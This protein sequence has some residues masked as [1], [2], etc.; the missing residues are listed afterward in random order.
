MDLPG[1]VL[2]AGSLPRIQAWLRSPAYGNS[3]TSNISLNI[4]LPLR[5]T[6]YDEMRASL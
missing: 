3:A 4:T 1:A 5:V 2:V 6:A